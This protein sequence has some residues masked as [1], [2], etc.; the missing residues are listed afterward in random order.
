MKNKQQFAKGSVDNMVVEP[1]S[2]SI[3][4]KANPEEESKPNFVAT[5]KTEINE[6]VNYKKGSYAFVV[7]LNTPIP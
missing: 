1:R 6:K 4:R 3:N 5:P 7:D 2:S